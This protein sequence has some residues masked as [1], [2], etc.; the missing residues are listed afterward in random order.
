MFIFMKTKF[1]LWGIKK[2]EN[3]K[4]S[5]QDSFIVLPH[6]RIIYILPF[7]TFSQLFLTCLVQC[8]GCVPGKHYVH[9][10][11]TTGRFIGKSGVR[12][13]GAGHRGVGDSQCVARYFS[14]TFFLSGEQ[15]IPEKRLQKTVEGDAFFFI[16]L[17]AWVR[18]VV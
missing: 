5:L 16:F 10:Y 14:S 1:L 6:V 15:R 8:F 12:A 18:I 11:V 9:F 7:Y 4:A 3:L 13:K 17:T 2:S